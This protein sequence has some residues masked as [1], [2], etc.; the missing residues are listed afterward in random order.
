MQPSILR[1]FGWRF[2]LVLTKDW[3]HNPDD[4]VSRLEKILHGQEIAD[5]PELQE[6]ELRTNCFT[7]IR[8]SSD[9]RVNPAFTQTASGAAEEKNT[10][11]PPP[12]PTSADAVRHFE[13]VGGSSQKFWEIFCQV[14]R[15]LC[16]LDVSERLASPKQRLCR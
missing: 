11:G 16:A 4:V 15:L 1:A 13:F 2:A 10:V 8:K 14:I 12:V 3:Y 5:E 9:N 6:E 7:H